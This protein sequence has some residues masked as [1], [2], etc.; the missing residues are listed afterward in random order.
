MATRQCEIGLH[1]CKER[2]TNLMYSTCYSF[3]L[4]GMSVALEKKKNAVADALSWVAVSA[5]TSV[6][7]PAMAV[8]HNFPQTSALSTLI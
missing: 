8:R 6:H 2:I 3:F 1:P 4:L 7:S 5:V